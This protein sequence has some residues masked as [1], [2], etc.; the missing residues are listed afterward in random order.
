[1]GEMIEEL[2]EI[3]TGKEVKGNAGKIKGL[4]GWLVLFQIS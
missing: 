3:V 2:K 4:G 1:M